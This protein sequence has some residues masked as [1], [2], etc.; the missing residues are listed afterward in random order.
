MIDEAEDIIFT[1]H[2]ARLPTWMHRSVRHRGR[3]RSCQDESWPSKINQ[4]LLYKLY[5]IDIDCDTHSCL[6]RWL[7]FLTWH[8]LNIQRAVNKPA[9]LEVR[10]IKEVKALIENIH[11]SMYSSYQEARLR[12]LGT[13][14]LWYSNLQKRY[15]P[16]EL[17]AHISVSL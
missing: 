7:A 6:C 11:N 10:K 14:S 13:F 16:K 12:K 2:A 8:H 3:Q 9:K 4:V 5:T 15:K 1:Y 17:N